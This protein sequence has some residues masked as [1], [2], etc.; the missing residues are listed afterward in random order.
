VTVHQS[1]IIIIWKNFEY[2]DQVVYYQTEIQNIII[3]KEK[4]ILLSTSK[5]FL[6]IWDI[7]FKDNIM[8]LDVKID[9]NRTFS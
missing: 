5:H 2:Y 6:H 9:L 1:G 8:N 7:E 4:Y 3:Y